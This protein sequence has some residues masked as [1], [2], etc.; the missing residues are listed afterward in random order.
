MGQAL[1][2]E[3]SLVILG[4]QVGI[5]FVEFAEFLLCGVEFVLERDLGGTGRLPLDAVRLQI[6]SN[7]VSVGPVGLDEPYR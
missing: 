5:E 3:R 7:P 1:R 4:I 6:E 2:H